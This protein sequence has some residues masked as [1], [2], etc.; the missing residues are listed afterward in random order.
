MEEANPRKV[1]SDGIMRD[2]I[3][4]FRAEISQCEF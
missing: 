1:D 4:K 3:T 2:R